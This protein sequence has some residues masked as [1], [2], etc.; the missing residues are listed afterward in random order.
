M[1]AD[2]VTAGLIAIAL[3]GYYKVKYLLDGQMTI[4]QIL[5]PAALW[6]V[7]FAHY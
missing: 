7:L 1:K 3:P 5:V 2:V 4:E 6:E